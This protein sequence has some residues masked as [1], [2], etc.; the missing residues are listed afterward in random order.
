MQMPQAALAVSILHQGHDGRHLQ[1]ELLVRMCQNTVR[2]G[3]LS[4]PVSVLQKPSHESHASTTPN[5]DEATIL[6][7][8]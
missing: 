2:L 7:D 8:Q 1:R 3:G 4:K 6:K 5:P